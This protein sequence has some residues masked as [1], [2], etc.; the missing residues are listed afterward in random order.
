MTPGIRFETQAADE[1]LV[2]LLRKHPVTNVM[3]ILIF[4]IMLLAPFILFPYLSWAGLITDVPVRFGLVGTIA[5]YLFTFIFAFENFISWYFNVYLLTN[6]RIL[7]V[8]FYNLLYKRVSE[9]RLDKIQDVTYTQSGM[10][11]NVFN[12]GFVYIQTAG[13]E[14]NLEFE[15]VPNPAKVVEAISK[16]LH[17]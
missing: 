5:W 6:E 1:E 9:A 2:L 11:Q 14:E 12:Y 4:I 3:W 8:D 13:T 16:L 7:D 15:S 17:K 10:A